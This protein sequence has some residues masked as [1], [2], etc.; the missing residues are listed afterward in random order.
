M[1]WTSLDRLMPGLSEMNGPWA[2]DTV[3]Y[4]CQYAG[5]RSGLTLLEPN[6]SPWTQSYGYEAAGNLAQRPND[7]AAAEPLLQTF[8]IGNSL[9][10]LTSV[11]RSGKLTVAG[12]TT[13]NA[14]SVTV[15]GVAAS[16]YGDATFAKDG[17]TI[18]DGVNGF[19][20]VAQR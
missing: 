14:T 2:E 18:A 13:T 10:Q 7:F 8:S 6:A 17:L 4:S 15:N 9:N 12:M 19:T 3:S 1:T 16:R 5:P 11:T 20:T